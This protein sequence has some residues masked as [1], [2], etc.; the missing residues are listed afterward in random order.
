[1]TWRTFGRN[2]TMNRHSAIIAHT[3]TGFS[4]R[5]FTNG[6]IPET[7][8]PVPVTWDNGPERLTGREI[9]LAPTMP[10]TIAQAAGKL[11]ARKNTHATVTARQVVLAD[12]HFTSSS[13]E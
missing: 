6:I 10:F 9:P 3:C 12:A 1:M 5:S 8:M 13:F 7:T 4:P 2:H 11:S